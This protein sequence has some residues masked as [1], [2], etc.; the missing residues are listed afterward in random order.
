VIERAAGDSYEI[1]VDLDN[2]VVS[3]DLG[4]SARFTADPYGRELLLRGS[5]RSAARCSKSRASPRT[6]GATHEDISHRLCLAT[7][8]D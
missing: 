4:F 1:A 2:G 6:S 8:S 5:T 7:A 3:D